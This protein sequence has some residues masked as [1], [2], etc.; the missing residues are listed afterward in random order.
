MSEFKLPDVGEG[1]TE[2]EIVAWKVKVGDVIEINDIIVEIE[3]AKSLVE[4]PSPYAGTVLALMV[5]EGETVAV[6]TPIISVCDPSEA[7][8]PAAPETAA[9]AEGAA[10]A[11]AAPAQAEMEIDLSNPRASGG[12]E[13]ESLVGRNKAERTAIRRSR[14]SAATAGVEAGAGAA[15]QQ[16]QGAFEPGPSPHVEGADEPAVPATSAR[17]SAPAQAAHA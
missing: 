7:P 14:K 5:P 12:G 16:L 11:P 1:L 13:G 10:A 8:A 17:T 6:G 2:A 9:P 3:T 4:L 15:N